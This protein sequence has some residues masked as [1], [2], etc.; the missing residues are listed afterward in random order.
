[1]PQEYRPV[2]VAIIRDAE[3]K[4]LFVQSAK[5]LNEWY[6]PQGGIEKQESPE[7]ALFR[8]IKEELFIDREKFTSMRYLGFADL[9][10][11]PERKDRRGFSKGKRYFF[12]QLEYTGS[13][14]VV[15][16]KSELENYTWV[17][18]NKIDDVLATTRKEKTKLIKSF[19]PR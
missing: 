10:A 9:D 2:A 18:T 12:F 15:V 16:Q 4:I 3:K 6:L 14:E 1:M 17:S 8:E 11:E 7:N 13:K 19:I 5:N